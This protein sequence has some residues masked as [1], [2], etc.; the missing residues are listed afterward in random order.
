MAQFECETCGTF[1]D[2]AIQVYQLNPVVGG[3]RK[4]CDIDCYIQWP[5]PV[6]PGDRIHQVSPL[7]RAIARVNRIH[8]WQQA[9]TAI[10]LVVVLCALIISIQR[11]TS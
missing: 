4:F 5:G 2:D 7:T 6:A 9:W 1:L 8:F 3:V 10:A 11:A